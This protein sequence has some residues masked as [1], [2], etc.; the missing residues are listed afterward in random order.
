MAQI[1]TVTQ[2]SVDMVKEMNQAV[3]GLL[4]QARALDE[5]VHR[6]HV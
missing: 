1:R 4:G 5:A 6:F 2:L 3:E